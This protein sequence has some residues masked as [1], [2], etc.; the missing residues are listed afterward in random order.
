M[1]AARNIIIPKWIIDLHGI[2]EA[3]ST[4]SNAKARIIDAIQ[5]GEMLIMRSVQHELNAAYEQLW[6]AFVAIKPKTYVDTSPRD[7][8]VAAQLQELN[9]SSLLGSVPSFAH[10]EAIA[11]AGRKGCKLVTAGKAFSDCRSISNKCGLPTTN[12][13]QINDV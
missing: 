10:F 6:D 4:R 3:L 1:A 2:K 7:S 9:G 13:L 11:L 8:A 12:V 5:S